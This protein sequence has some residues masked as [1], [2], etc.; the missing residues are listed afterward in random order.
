EP[1]DK[2]KGAMLSDRTL[3][4]LPDAALLK[5]LG[6]QI[7][8]GRVRDAE[9]FYA[10]AQEVRSGWGMRY[11]AARRWVDRQALVPEGPY[12]GR[13]KATLLVE[14][15]HRAGLRSWLSQTVAANVPVRTLADLRAWCLLQIT[16]FDVLEDAGTPHFCVPEQEPLLD[17][18][19]L[20]LTAPL[21]S[22]K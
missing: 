20:L 19:L 5:K 2:G 7:P 16:A 15:S 10:H 4:P 3:G 14:E 9:H 6:L 17:H 11:D 22:A 13:E 21:F 18:D 1:R 8:S 12:S